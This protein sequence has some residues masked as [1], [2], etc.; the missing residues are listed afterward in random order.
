MMPD[1]VKTSGIVR[2]VSSSR[3]ESRL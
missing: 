1:M 3:R 2:I